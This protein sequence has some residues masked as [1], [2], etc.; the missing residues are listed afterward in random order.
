[1]LGNQNI[2][3]GR[4]GFETA[5]RDFFFRGDSLAGAVLHAIETADPSC[6]AEISDATAFAHRLSAA[7]DGRVLA[8]L[9]DGGRAELRAIRDSIRGQFHAQNTEVQ[10]TELE[11]LLA[12]SR[13][14]KALLA[15]RHSPTP[16]GGDTQRL[17]QFVS[18]HRTNVGS[19]PFLAGLSATL[20]AQLKESRCVVWLLDDAVLTQS[21]GLAFAEATVELLVEG[22]GFEHS[23]PDDLERYSE[24]SR[25]SAFVF[26]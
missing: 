22:L 9:S 8:S 15:G 13:E 7:L 5:C 25:V 23:T 17:R 19:H 24:G 14:R 2:A 10:R 21:G 16:P 11:L 26:Y 6:P 1:M 20:G 18:S 4:A 3:S 12:A